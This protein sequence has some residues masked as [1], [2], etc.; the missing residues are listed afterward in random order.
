METDIRTS[1]LSRPPSSPREC[2][3]LHAPWSH[4]APRLPTLHQKRGVTAPGIQRRPEPWRYQTV[5]DLAPN[6]SIVKGPTNP[7]NFVNPGL[8]TSDAPIGAQTTCSGDQKYCRVSITSSGAIAPPT[9]LWSP[10]S[11]PL[12]CRPVRRRNNT[13]NGWLLLHKR[14]FI[15][16]RAPKPG[17][18]S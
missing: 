6:A 13:P 15:A 1:M 3:P 11:I 8:I 12:C 2:P 16:L 17:R 4:R 10:Q 9:G 5:D 7:G 14:L 18:V